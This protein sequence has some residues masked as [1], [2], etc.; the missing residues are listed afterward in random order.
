MSSE[1]PYW[2]LFCE[3]FVRDWNLVSR[4]LRKSPISRE[5]EGWLFRISLHV[6]LAT[7]KRNKENFFSANLQHFHKRTTIICNCDGRLVPLHPKQAMQIAGIASQI[8]SLAYLRIGKVSQ[9]IAIFLGRLQCKN[10]GY[11]NLAHDERYSYSFSRLKV[12]ILN[13]TSFKL[14]V[15]FSVFSLQN[16]NHESKE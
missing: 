13:N 6:S 4:L 12:R 9:S 14:N 3:H 8:K 15:H 10:D 7:H 2:T 5:R 1:P 16:W 11:Q